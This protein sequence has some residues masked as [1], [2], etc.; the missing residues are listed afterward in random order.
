M[1]VLAKHLICKKGYKLLEEYVFQGKLPADLVD[2]KEKDRDALFNNARI[3]FSARKFEQAAS[4]CAL[5]YFLNHR[6]P[7]Y[8]ELYGACMIHMK[9]YDEA[10][11]A[12]ARA[13]FLDF[14]NPVYHF[15]LAQITEIQDGMKAA[16][17]AYKQIVQ[18]C[19]HVQDEHAPAV[20]KAAL[21]KL[22]GEA[23][24]I[25]EE[26]NTEEKENTEEREDAD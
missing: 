18:F 2:M 8:F 16:R 19:D 12:F 26:K 4:M 17:P 1:A 7:K 6:N 11:Q 14:K 3:S 23:A 5:L 20:R 21:Q 25:T 24:G 13:K 22:R 9:K 15:Y 10:G